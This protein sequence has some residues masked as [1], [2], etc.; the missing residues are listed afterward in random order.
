MEQIVDFL[1]ILLEHMNNFAD[2]SDLFWE[3]VILWIVITYF[4]LKLMVLE[5]TYSIA[6]TIIASTGI[7]NTILTAWAGVAPDTMAVLGYLR[8]PESINLILS[9]YVTR[10][11]LDMLP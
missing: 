10:F 8:I 1:N 9:A 2:S 11:I 7:S 5:F 4:E 3:R 6:A